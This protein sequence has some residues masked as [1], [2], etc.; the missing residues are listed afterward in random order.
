MIAMNV[1][2]GSDGPLLPSGDISENWI[3]KSLPMSKYQIRADQE[4]GRRK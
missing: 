4:P 2:D 3:K 1:L